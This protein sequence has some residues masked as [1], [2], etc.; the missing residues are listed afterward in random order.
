MVKGKNTAG[1]DLPLPTSPV[2]VTKSELAYQAMRDGIVNGLLQAGDRLPSTRVL[3]Q[4][5]GVG[6]GTLEY[7]FE[8]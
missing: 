5:W 8:R 4:R 2:G 3:S 7:V 1:L 6:R